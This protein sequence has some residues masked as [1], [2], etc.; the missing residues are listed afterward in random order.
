MMMEKLLTLTKD[1][2][3]H[4]SRVGGGVLRHDLDISCTIIIRVGFQ[5]FIYYQVL[6]LKPKDILTF[7]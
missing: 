3:A 6:N 1:I 7:S 5:G 4:Y 2:S